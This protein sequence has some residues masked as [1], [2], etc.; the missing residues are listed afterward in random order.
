MLT[1]DP[2]SSDENVLILTCMTNFFLISALIELDTSG[3][4]QTAFDSGDESFQLNASD[5]I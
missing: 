4:I 3:F 5:L 1:A 2:L